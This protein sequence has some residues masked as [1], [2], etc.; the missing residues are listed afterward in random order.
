LSS[1]Y[2][3]IALL[4]PSDLLTAQIWREGDT[5]YRFDCEILAIDAKSPEIK[6]RHAQSIERLH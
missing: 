6:L 5:E 4:S 2:I 1:D 3:H